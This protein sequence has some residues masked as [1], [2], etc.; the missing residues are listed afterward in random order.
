MDITNRTPVTGDANMKIAIL[1]TGAMGSR[2]AT[3]LQTVGGHQVTVW[4]RTPGPAE[5]LRTSGVTTASSP[6]EAAGGQ[7]IVL[8]MLRDDDAARAVWIE[9][10]ALD[11]M[12]PGAIA[13][14][15][16]TVS[17]EWARELARLGRDRSLGVLDCPVVGS[18]P[19]AEAGSLTLLVGG[20]V[21][22]LERARPVLETVGYAVHHVGVAGAGSQLKLAINAL[23]AAQVAMVAEHLAAL[24]GTDVETQRA[25]EV[26]ASSPVASPAGTAAASSILNQQFAPNFPIELVVKDLVY[27]AADAR[28]R[29]KAM[30]L[31]ESVLIQYERASEVCAGANIT[32]IASLYDEALA[33]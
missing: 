15:S 25:A 3:R 26:I 12:T 8:S 6:A 14:E 31:T 7:D 24:T 16:S 9:G 11:A 32:G 33:N 1:G 21:A 29:G 23:F 27:A 5:E 17:P 20:D 19:H 13:I 28:A 2:I 10:G 4:N 22:V 18:R 30:P